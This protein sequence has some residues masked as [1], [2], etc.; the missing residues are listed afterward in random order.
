MES[1]RF[2]LAVILMIAVV[3]VTN[4]IFPPVRPE[5]GALSPDS[6]AV[7]TPPAASPDAPA[8][9]TSD[10]TGAGAA[11]VDPA[12]PATVAGAADTVWVDGPLWRYGISTAGG[13]LVYAQLDEYESTITPGDPVQLVPENQGLLSH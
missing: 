13:A 4:L 12:L 9:T 5:P 7:G 11:T 6:A 3:I 10:D 1:G 8:L 2:L